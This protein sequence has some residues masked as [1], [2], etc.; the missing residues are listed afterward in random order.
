[1]ALIDCTNCGRRITDQA[2]SCPG[3]GVAM[4]RFGKSGLEVQAESPVQSNPFE[5]WLLLAVAFAPFAFLW[6]LLG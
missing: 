3:C 1:M 4:D 5:L 2:V 6:L